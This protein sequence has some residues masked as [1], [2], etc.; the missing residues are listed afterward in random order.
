MFAGQAS[1]DDRRVM[2][3]LNRGDAKTAL[4]H[5]FV[6]AIRQLSVVEQDATPTGERI[7]VSDT[8]PYPTTRTTLEAA[9]TVFNLVPCDRGLEERFARWLDTTASDVLAFAKNE[10]ATHFEVPYVSYRGGLRY[11]RPDFLVRTPHAMY[12]IETKGL[13]DLEVP[14]KDQRM[15]QWCRDASEFSGSPWRYVKVAGDLFDSQPWDSIATLE[16]AAR[17]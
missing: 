13:E 11:Y 10:T 8:N 12:V 6:R 16:R 5:I 7:R 2:S 4:F 9:K 15:H 3:R 17:V 14:L 1:M